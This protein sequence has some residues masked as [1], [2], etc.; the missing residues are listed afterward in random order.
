MGVM[1]RTELVYANNSVTSLSSTYYNT[2]DGYHS[3]SLHADNASRKSSTLIVVVTIRNG[4][5]LK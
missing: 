3:T 5:E 4:L 2:C 1:L